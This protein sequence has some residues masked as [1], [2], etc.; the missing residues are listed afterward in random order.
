MSKPPKAKPSRGP[1]TAPAKKRFPLGVV[2]LLAL[3]AVVLLGFWL[4]RPKPTATPNATQPPKDTVSNALAAA[5][6]EARPEF[7]RLKGKWLRPD[8][9]YV[10][11]IR[12]VDRSGKLDAGYF[13]PD[14]IYVARAN[15]L[16]EGTVTRVFVELR[17]VNY[18]GSTYTLVYDSARDELKGVY[19][20]AAL[21]QSFVIFFERSK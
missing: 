7:Q 11:D 18:P 4:N 8:G 12:G 5:V 15:A 16:Q 17:D 10:L 3:A 19:Y 2:S 9:G 6:A 20:Q 1:A 14:P 13:N 21:Q